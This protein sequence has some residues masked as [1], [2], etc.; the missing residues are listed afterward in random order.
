MR[1]LPVLTVLA[2]PFGAEA[3]VIHLANGQVISGTVLSCEGSEILVEPPAS[4]SVLIKVA[5]VARGEGAGIERCLGGTHAPGSSTVRGQWYGDEI[6]VAGGSSLLLLLLAAGIHS[7]GLALVSFTGIALSPAVLH[8]VHGNV[9]RAFG[10]LGIHFALGTAGLFL[11]SA[12]APC[13]GDLC[14]LQALAGAGVG[15]LLT[16]VIA[17]AIDAYALAYQQIP[18][19]LSLG[20]LPPRPR[21]DGYAMHR[22]P[23]GIQLSV[24]F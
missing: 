7:P 16:Q 22:G 14:G 13:N 3:D 11:G 18:V 6:L 19:R 21:S 8:V 17:S 5:D 4:R 9:G 23:A 24:R 15:V 12:L 2:I 10:S 20:I 1:F